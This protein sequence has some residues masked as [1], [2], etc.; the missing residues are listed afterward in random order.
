MQTRDLLTGWIEESRAVTRQMASDLA[1]SQWL[2]PRL[3][4]VNPVLWEIGHVAWFQEKWV[5]RHACGRPPLHDHADRL[6]DSETVPHETRWDLPLL[7]WDQVWRYLDEV[8]ARVQEQVARWPEDAPE[9]YYAR[10]AVLHEDMHAEALCYTRQ[11][12]GWSSPPLAGAV[13]APPAGPLPGDVLHHGGSFEMGGRRDDM[14]VFDNE[15]WSHAVSVAPFRMARAA[16]TEGEFEAFVEDGGYAREALWSA[17]GWAWRCAQGIHAP[18]YWRREGGGWLRRVF[19]TERPIQPHRPMMH[20]G[21]YEAEA[22]CRWAQRRLPTEAEWELAAA[23]AATG[24]LDAATLGPADVADAPHSDSTVGCRQMLGNVWEWTA[25]LFQPYPGFS[26]DPYA[27][28]SQPWFGTHR[29][30]RGGCW[31]TSSR[32][33]RRTY[34][35]FYLP[36]RRDVWA[37]FRTCAR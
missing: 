21:W 6:Y 35:N 25:D 24:T 9:L 22:W 12:Q 26:P 30:L 14:F 17:D 2:G 31:V 28:Y 7:P 5:L 32:I 36:E 18:L 20:V 1:P 4:I 13:P 37:G 8:Q 34:R 29:V 15:K 11:T 10:L 27:T 19:D 3:D 23:G 33:A 16:V